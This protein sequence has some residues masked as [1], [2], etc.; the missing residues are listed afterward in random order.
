M[1]QHYEQKQIF[2]LINQLF[3]IIFLCYEF[4]QSSIIGTTKLVPLMLITILTIEGA[5]ITFVNI[6]ENS[7]LSQFL[8]LVFLVLWQFLFTLNEN[9]IPY[10]LSILL[11]V[12]ILYKTVRFLLLFFFQDSTYVYK[13]ETDLLLKIVCLSALAA[14]LINDRLFAIL[15][16]CQFVLSFCCIAFLFLKHRKRITFVLKSEK[17]HLLQSIVIIVLPFI[18]Y[19]MVFAGNPEYLSNSGWY[20]IIFIPICSIHAIAFKNHKF[21]KRYFNL[22]EGK[23]GII[24]VF[25]FIG[26]L[27]L[28]A[29]FKWNMLTYFIIIH[30][31]LGFV[32][33][34]FTLL[35]KDIKNTILNSDTGVPKVLHESFYANNLLQIIKEEELKKDFSNYLHD[36][37]L[38]DLLSVKNMV[39]KSNVK[40][41]REIIE[42]TLDNLNVSIREQMQE[43]HPTLLKTLTLKE[44]Y[45]N[46]LAMVQQKYPMKKVD[47]SFDCDEHLFL[48]EPYHLVVYR[49]LK[50]LVINTFKH[51]KCSKLFVRLTQKNNEIELIVKD[52]GVGLKMYENYVSTEHRG[53]NSIKEQL[54]LLNGKMTILESN[55][56]G[57]CITIR[58]PMKGDDSY[59]YFINR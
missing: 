48:V 29:L 12:V 28:G 3:M 21:M 50:E 5:Y 9:Q 59:E 4:L 22:K 16:L 20:I 10:T 15:L 11:S 51:S 1:K 44:N 27:S 34:Y 13:K 31:I 55:P 40:E 54:L 42:T 19:T 35:Y 49:I 33:L 46:L 18:G 41:I 25:A 38:Q 32:L 37:V 47:L 17:K 8:N 57:L 24:S 58:I 45:S 36:E 43:Y 52:N 53:L 26:V 39:N 23:I 56:S 2:L 6:K 14:K 30:T 7:T